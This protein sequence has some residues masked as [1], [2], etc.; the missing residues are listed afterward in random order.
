MVKKNRG[1]FISCEIF[2][3]PE[4]A[5]PGGMEGSLM[6]TQQKMERKQKPQEME[7]SELLKAIEEMN[8]ATKS[9]FSLDMYWEAQLA[10]HKTELE[11]KDQKIRELEERI[12]GT[13]LG[14]EG[15]DQS[16]LRIVLVGKT[17]NGKSATGNTILQS[18]KF[19]SESSSTSV[20]TC[21]QKR[22]GEVAGRRVS[23]VDTPGLF[24]TSMSNEEVQEEI[25]KCISYLAPG[26][27][28]FLLV[29]QIGRITKEEKDTLQL[30]KS[31]FGKMAEMFTMVLFTRGDD[32]NKPIESFIEN[33][34]ATIQ[35]LIKGCG[36]RFHVFNNKDKSNI[37]Q[38]SELLH[39]IDMMVQKNGGG[40][41]TNEMF[42]EAEMTIKKECERILRE[43]EGEMQ[44]EREELQAKHE[45]EMKEMKGRME[46]QRLKEEGERAHREKELKE[47][48]ENLRKE[49][50]EWQ[51]KEEEEKE[52]TAE[53]EKKRKEIQEIE[54]KKKIDEIEGEKSRMNEEWKRKEE[55]EKKKERERRDK[56][57]EQ[58]REEERE[59]LAELQ[60]EFERE[61]EEERQKRK[62]KDQHF[63]AA[64]RCA[65][66]FSRGDVPYHQWMD[67]VLDLFKKIEMMNWDNG[68]SCYTSQMFLEAEKA[69]M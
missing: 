11:E 24:D 51:K 28:V 5:A 8:K 23:V 32:I 65:A 31:T 53:E 7:V 20:T 26:P 56:E 46:E 61:R 30:I 67:Q 59:R 52:K 6:G 44:R 40:C 49:R 69:M 4:S 57:D 48:E 58:R 15:K 47:K 66:F 43:R 37:T 38:V 60:E 68:G 63:I 21:C 14:V 54:W 35:N 10:R 13:S 45:E 12:D 27:H 9:C 33:G 25:A 19:L 41:Y 50:E 18:E 36:D 17:G 55:E 34:D 22:V 39:K 2:Q 16:C 1:G 42:Q 62:K 3:E 64:I 29:L